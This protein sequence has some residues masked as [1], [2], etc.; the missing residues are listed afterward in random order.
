MDPDGVNV[1]KIGYII[2]YNGRQKVGWWQVRGVLTSI[3]PRPRRCLFSINDD[4]IFKYYLI[5]RFTTCPWP[6]WYVLR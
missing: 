4:S 3:F 2:E 5:Y 6:A 1:G